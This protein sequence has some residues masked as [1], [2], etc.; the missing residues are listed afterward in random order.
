ME[1]ATAVFFEAARKSA[2]Y[3][4]AVFGSSPASLN[5][6]LFQVSAYASTPHVEYPYILPPPQSEMATVS[7]DTED[8]Q[9]LASASGIGTS[10]PSLMNPPIQEKSIMPMSGAL[11]PA[12]AVKSFCCMVS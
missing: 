9:A 7:G 11:P 2:Q 10:A 6:V 3:F 12:S 4:G 8:I 5:I 1:S